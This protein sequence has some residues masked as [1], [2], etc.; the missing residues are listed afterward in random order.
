[1]LGYHYSMGVES[2]NG[3]SFAG[4]RDALIEQV[5]AIEKH[6]AVRNQQH[7]PGGRGP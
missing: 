7:S 5:T 3:L 2:R 1:M 4:I 6:N